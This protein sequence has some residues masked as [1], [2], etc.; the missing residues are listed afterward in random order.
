MKAAMF[1]FYGIAAL[2]GVVTLVMPPQTIEAV[3][4]SVTYVWSAFVLIGGAGGVIAVLPGWW[5]MERLCIACL[6]VGIGIYAI[7]LAYLHLSE[8]GSRL[9]QLGFLI[10]AAGLFYIRLLTIRTYSFDPR[11]DRG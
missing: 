5:W 1:V 8:S 2:T 6:W 9:T 3:I 10:L 11:T 7:V 4:G